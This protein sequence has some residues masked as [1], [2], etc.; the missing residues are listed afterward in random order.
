MDNPAPATP[1]T[2]I[3]GESELIFCDDTMPGITRRKVR[4]GWGYWDAD[5]NRIEDR[6]E[7]ERLNKIALPPAYEN[8]WFSPF[9]NGHILATGIDAKGRKQYRYHPDFRSH[10]E[11][12]KFDTCASFGRLLP[13]VRKRVQGDLRSPRLSRERAVASVVRLLDT[14]GI[15]VGNESYAKT[16]KSFGATTLRKRHAKLQGQVLKLRFKAKSGQDREMRITDKSLIRFVRRMQ[17]LPGQHL[18]RYID[19]DGEACPVTSSDVNV[20]LRETMGGPYTAKHFRTWTASAYAFELLASAQGKLP[21]KQ[22]LADVS[23]RLGNTPVIARKSYIHPVVLA[24]VPDQ[25]GWRQNLRLPRATQ[26]LSRYERGLIALLEA[27]PSAGEVLKA[28]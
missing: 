18:F 11:C 27:A 13:Q 3:A 20:Y 6:E 8:A 16:N 1:A 12:E 4:H 2:I 9:A 21:L 19:A 5:G 22:L 10:R 7:I 23:D 28:A 14:G 25:V 26:W 17:D 15:R 24:L